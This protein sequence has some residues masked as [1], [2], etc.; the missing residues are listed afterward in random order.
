MVVGPGCQGTLLTVL[1][2]SGASRLAGGASAANAPGTC[3]LTAAHY[4]RSM[5]HVIEIAS[6]ARAKCRACERKID[7]GDLRF[8]ERQPNAF[9]DGEM[10]LWFHLPCA[11]YRRPEPFLEAAAA[12]TQDLTPLIAVAE[13]SIAHRRLPRLTLAERSPTG[14]AHCRR[15]KEL[16]AKDKWRIGISFFDEFRFQPGGFVHATCAPAYFETADLVD[17]IRHFSPDLDSAALTELDAV[18]RAAPTALA[19]D[20]GAEP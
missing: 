14:R 7:K 17:R 2:V 15:C 16:I 18:L 10:T 8:G 4:N 5:P 19:P 1:T 6:S 3:T 13:S 12:A 9:G 20:E 11:A